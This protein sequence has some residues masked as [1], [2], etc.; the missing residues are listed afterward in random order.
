MDTY[1]IYGKS[2]NI[3]NE[4]INNIVE[5]GLNII[6]YDLEKNS[7]AE[8]IEEAATFSLFSTQKYIVIKNSII[9]NSGKTNEE[10]IKMLIKYLDNQNSLST[11]IFVTNKPLDERKKVVKYFRKNCH[12]IINDD[13]N[14]ENLYNKVMQI[15]QKNGYNISKFGINYIIKSG[16]NNFD[17]I[18][19]EIKKILLYKLNDKN[20]SD[21]DIINL[22]ATNYDDNIF[23]F[24]NAVI[25]KNIKESFLILEDLKKIK[26]EEIVLI[27]ILEKQYRTILQC[28]ILSKEGHDKK[29]IASILKENPNVIWHAL[30]N[31]YNYSQEELE[32]KITALANLDYNI[33]SGKIDKYVGL[34]LYLLNI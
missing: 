34:N 21:D 28:K 32:E 23:K 10:E 3:N 11:L 9:F 13:L 27:F 25:N 2:N 29:E 22:V 14:E 6:H 31:G 20:I 5:N 15:F 24:T 4:C 16:L 30:Q 7:I 19:E 18:N 1:L 17:I 33:K 26:V 12:V 8:I